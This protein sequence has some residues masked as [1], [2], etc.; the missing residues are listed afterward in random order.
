MDP[1]ENLNQYINF[2]DKKT[3]FIEVESADHYCIW[4]ENYPELPG[5]VSRPRERYVNLLTSCRII[6]EITMIP[7]LLYQTIFQKYPNHLK[8]K[9]Y[10]TLNSFNC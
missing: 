4:D 1:Y 3:G 2:K 9:L 8:A 7:Y 5:R 10:F 6:I